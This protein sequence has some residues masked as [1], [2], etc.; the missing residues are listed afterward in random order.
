MTEFLAGVFSEEF[1]HALLN[2]WS[3]TD[4]IVRNITYALLLLSVLMRNISWLR[5]FA[6][7][8]GTGRIIFEDPVTAFWETLLVTI[9]VIQLAL[10]WWDNRK[11]RFSPATEQFLST[12]DPRLGNAAA[13][14]L[15]KA[16]YWREASAGAVLTT[17]GIPV[18]SLIYIASG[19]VRIEVGG[20]QVGTC[21]TGD[22]LGEMTWQSGKP[23][24]GTAVAADLVTYLR[25]DRKRLKKL[26]DKTPEL[27]FALQTSFNR[28]L[29][30]KLVRSNQ[31]AQQA[32]IATA[33]A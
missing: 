12:F 13:A 17:Q 16:G 20:A 11:R 5:S 28:N 23:A 22:F 30:D 31:G 14:A 18:D 6:I 2:S 10:I 25:F 19:E 26:L 8:S 33:Q 21:S 3:T 15:V 4:D 7:A 9:N 1:V 29:V 24:T 32:A 27:K